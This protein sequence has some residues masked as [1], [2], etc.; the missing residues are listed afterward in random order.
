[1]RKLFTTLLLSGGLAVVTAPKGWAEKKKTDEQEETVALADVPPAVRATIEKEA[2]GA[3]L[4]K[5]EQSTSK[6]G[7]VVYELEIVKSGQQ[8][9]ILIAADG[10]VLKRKAEKPGED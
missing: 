7:Q 5:I 9:E 1:M 10:T 6:K 8:Y 3:H 2:N 4:K